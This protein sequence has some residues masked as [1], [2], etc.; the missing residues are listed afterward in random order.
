MESIYA[1]TDRCL[2]DL[3]VIYVMSL[4][5]REEQKHGEFLIGATRLA[6]CLARLRVALQSLPRPRYWLAPGHVLGT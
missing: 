1:V 5:S 3:Q 2:L 4:I 6:L